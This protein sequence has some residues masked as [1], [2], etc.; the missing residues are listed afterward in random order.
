M[1]KYM[2]SLLLLLVAAGTIY[3]S[4][5]TAPTS[6]KV[7]NANCI[8]DVACNADNGC[9][10]ITHTYDYWF[11]LGECQGAGGTTPEPCTMN[12]Q[13]CNHHIDYADMD[14]SGFVEERMHY[15]YGCP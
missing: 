4:G 1:K 8:S 7:Y 5:E 14:C 9:S 15:Q 10:W 3:G 2:F 13:L 6:Y 11:H 12:Y